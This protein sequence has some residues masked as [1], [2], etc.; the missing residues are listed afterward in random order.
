[1]KTII[2][3]ALILFSALLAMVGCKSDDMEYN[4]PLVTA[5]DGL[6]APLNNQNVTLR[7]DEGA[8]L[9]FQW[10]ASQAQDGQGASYEV[11][12]FKESDKVNPIYRVAADN[13]GKEV[14]AGV[15]H[16]DIN[17]AAS[18]AGIPTGESGNLYWGVVSWR[19][20][21][22]A[23]S[24]QIN[25]IMVKRLEG[26]EIIPEAVYITGDATE[27]GAGLE[28]AIQM[29]DM[30]NGKFEAFTELNST[31]SFVFIDR[32]SGTPEKFY[33]D[34]DGKL[35]DADNDETIT[36]GSKSVYRITLDFNT[37]GAKIQKIGLVQ[38]VM[39]TPG[40]RITMPYIGNGVW[41]VNDIRPDFKSRWND[42]RY[43]Y[44]MNVDGVKYRVGHKDWDAGTPGSTSGSY[45]NVG[46]FGEENDE[47]GYSFK[48]PGQ[49]RT[50]GTLP[51]PIVVVDMILYMNN[52]KGFTNE[53]VKK[54]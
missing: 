29:R 36:V 34:A 39:A 9:R 44:E 51:T 28:N 12:F 37:K 10:A 41:R 18:A 22:S 27:G 45:F 26:F 52:S 4:D 40:Q 33:I 35:A 54:Y 7:S 38:F 21:N 20:M 19:G 30:G 5:V 1:M 6:Y 48:F 49:F 14:Y 25:S 53:I 15:S 23:L 32:L 2:Y 24:K 42:D 47:W 8:S 31:G 43:F 50:D 17:R 46:F 16:M 11:V 13:L 3:K